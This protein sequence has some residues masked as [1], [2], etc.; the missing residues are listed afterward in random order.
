MNT[1]SRRFIV[2]ALAALVLAGAFFRLHDLGK[3][4]LR[5]DTITFWTMCQQ[6]VTAGQIFSQWM[7]LMGISGQFPFAMAYTKWTLDTFHLPLTEFNLRLPG[8]IWGIL[9]ILCAY[10]AGRAFG[11]AWHGLCLAMIVALSP[12]HIQISGEAYYYP[13]LIA[14]AFLTVWAVLWMMDCVQG[15][16]PLTWSFYLI[17]TAG[18]FLV[19]WSQPTGWPFAFLAALVIVGGAAWRFYITRRQGMLV[20]VLVSL[21]IVGLPLLLADWG[22]RHMLANAAA[23]KAAGEKAVAASEGNAWTMLVGVVTS[24]AWGKT[25]LRAAFSLAMLASGVAGI[26]VLKRKEWKG[27]ALL[28]LLIVGYLLYLVARAKAGAM[29]E[30]RYVGVLY[31]IYALI[32]AEGIVGT[33][34][35]LGRRVPALA[36]RAGAIGGALAAVA[37]LL[38]LYPAYASNQVTGQPTPYKDI[39]AW[40]NT[41][42]TPGTLVLVDRWFEPWN[43]LRVYPSTNVFFAFTLPNEP[44][45]NYINYRWRDSAINFFKQFPDAAYLEIAKSYFTVPEV[46]PWPWPRSHFKQHVVITNEAGIRLRDLGLAN[47]SDYYVGNTNRLIVEIFYNTREDV[48]AAAR[49]QG[50]RVLGLFGPG[51]GYMKFWQQLQDFRDWRILE[52]RAQLDLY[53]LT[54]EPLS[55]EVI[56]HGVALD[57]PKRVQTSFGQ[58]VDFPPLQRTPIATVPVSLG[59]L[60]LHPGLNTIQLSDPVWSPDPAR[61]RLN[62]PLVVDRVEV[63]L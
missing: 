20:G 52:G 25:P 19:T 7:R 26:V 36:P 15:R 13:P 37:A 5:A 8:A 9:T 10:G 49:L 21:V 29:Y 12:I 28:A 4:S 32:L 59:R 43:E 16:R 45:D 44:V 41:H 2:V 56:L 55:G 57:R 62:A 53:N 46:G 38:S 35:W 30:A 6:P 14:G 40:F 3:P 11:T 54:D 47:R 63:R 58:G 27:P 48:T 23:G 1:P 34:A 51:W 60:T 61:A 50:E 17:N 22:L 18:F 39:Q 42:L 31:P 33:G 24:F